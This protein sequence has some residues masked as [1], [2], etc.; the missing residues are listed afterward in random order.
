MEIKKIIQW[1]FV[2]LF[3]GILSAQNTADLKILG[4]PETGAYPPFFAN[5]RLLSIHC[6][7][8]GERTVRLPKKASQVI[9]LLTGEVVARKTKSFKVSFHSPDTRLYEI[10]K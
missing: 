3:P 5:E 2:S 10:V 4:T 7:E 9:D 6:K 1:L 8:G